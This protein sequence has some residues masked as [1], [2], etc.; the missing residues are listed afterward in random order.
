MFARALFGFGEA[1]AYIMKSYCTEQRA[2]ESD[3]DRREEGVG[4][5]FGRSFFALL[6]VLCGFLVL[7]GCAAFDINTKI[8]SLSENGFVARVPETAKQREVY[9]A[10]PAYKL[11]RG[12][13]KGNVFY[14]YKDEK[15]G[16]VYVGTEA[17]YQRYMEKVRRLVAAFETTEDK[18]V[19]QDMDSD[20]QS[21][22]YGTWDNLGASNPRD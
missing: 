7:N 4:D 11:L 18:M 19:A 8:T 10:L 6:A 1:V 16:V 2:E 22:W 21:R 12:A 14:A 15:N 5:Q 9:A 17:E 13:V 20:L 3:R